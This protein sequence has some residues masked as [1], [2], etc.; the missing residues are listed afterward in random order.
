MK[1]SLS[2]VAVSA[3]LSALVAA[4]AFA[5]DF[6]YFQKQPCGELAKES[7]S[8]V[9]AEAAING[10]KKGKQTEAQIKNAVGFLLTGWPFW[11]SADHG[12]AD[13]QL[14]E[15]RADLKMVKAAQKTN[16]CSI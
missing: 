10:G 13:A 6:A 8:L 1:L 15:I 12:N 11:T 16:K 5:V 9:K 4:P 3:A 7:D 2:A 14:A